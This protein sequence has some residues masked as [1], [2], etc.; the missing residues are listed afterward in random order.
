MNKLLFGLMLI[1]STSALASEVTIRAGDRVNERVN[2]YNFTGPV[3]EVFDDGVVKF[4]VEGTNVYKY[5]HFTQLGKSVPCHK[6]VCALNRVHVDSSVGTV[7][8]VFDNDNVRIVL[9]GVYGYWYK[10]TAEL[11]NKL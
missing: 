9:D 1:S 3:V 5:V 8:E 4:L 6:G 11:G 7:S 2:E 10:T